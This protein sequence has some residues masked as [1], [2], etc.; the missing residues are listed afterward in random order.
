[1]KGSEVP[2]WNVAEALSFDHYLSLGDSMSI[3][4]YA[5]P[6]LGAASL[7]YRNR[8]AT[9]P[10]FR[11]RDLV[12]ANPAV[13]FSAMA[14]DG[15]TSPELERVV[16]ALPLDRARTLV[17]LTVGGNDLLDWWSTGMRVR[18]EATRRLTEFSARMDRILA[19]LRDKLPRAVLLMGNVYDPTDGSGRL[20]S[21]HSVAAGL[22][23]LAAMKRAL[24][25]LAGRAGAR[26]CDV[27]RHF[28][29]HG[30]RHAD[31][32]FEG[33]DAADPSGWFVYDIEPNPRGSSEI[34]RLFLEALP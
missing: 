7:L 1:V 18:E 4:K 10:A 23:V 25:V 2:A 17:T 14:E 5:G 8:D 26:L 6:G 16:A 21:G 33:Y 3:D 19:A 15:Q 31:P 24:A 28:L 9:W 30:M 27:H 22:P 34:R 20:Q 11:G 13:R 12:S 32:S 29:G